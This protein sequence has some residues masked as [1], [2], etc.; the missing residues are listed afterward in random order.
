[1]LSIA[2]LHKS[3]LKTFNLLKNIQVAQNTARK[4]RKKKW[5]ENNRETNSRKTVSKPGVSETRK[6]NPGKCRRIAPRYVYIKE[7]NGELTQKE[8]VLW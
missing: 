1:M 6:Q 4:I 7:G 5:G 3:Q 8:H 2:N